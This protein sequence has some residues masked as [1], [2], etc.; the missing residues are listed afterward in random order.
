MS[1]KK[2]GFVAGIA[3]ALS[4]VVS[5]AFAACSLTTMSECDN[6]GLMTLIASLLGGSSTTTTTTTTTGASISGIPAGFTFTTN[7]KQGT[8][9]NDVKYLQVLLNSN[10]ATSIGNAGKETTYFGAMTK[11]AVVKFQNFYKSETLTPYGLTAGT[12]FFGSSSRAKANALIAGGTTGTVTTYPA[13]CTSSTGFSSTTGQSCAGGTTTTPVVVGS[14]FT[15]ILASNNP[16]ANALVAGQA[17]SDIAHYT[18]SNGT[19]AAVNVTSVELTRIGISADS[20]LANVYLFNGATRVTDAGSVSSGKVT[21]NNAAGLFT[22]PANSAVTISV[23]SDI[24]TG[25]A[26]QTVGVS[27]SAVTSTGTLANTVLPI[28]GNLFTI[29]TAP[30]LATVRIAAPTPTLVNGTPTPTDPV[31]GVRVWESTFTLSNNVTFTRLALKQINS[32]NSTDIGNFQLL[33]N[34]ELVS[35]V[36]SLDSNNYVTFSFNKTL[37]GSPDV[38]VLAD[39]NGGSSRIVQMSLRSAADI[40]IKD[41]QYGVNLAPLS[42]SLPASANGM[43][44]NSGQFTVA[45]DN[46]V[47]P[48][49][50]SNQATNVRIGKFTFKATGEAVKVDTITAGFSTTGAATALK[51]GKIFI[52][53]IQA[54]STANLALATA[55]TGGTSYTVNYTFQ[56]GVVTTV[57]IYADIIAATGTLAPTNLITGYIVRG[58][59]NGTP[60]ISLSTINVPSSGMNAASVSVGTGSATIAVTSN[61]GAQT[62]VAPQTAFKIG[63]WNITAGTSENINVND[64]V[65]GVNGTHGFDS[66]DL[67]NMYVTYQVGSGSAVTTSI[68]PT[69][70]TSNDFPVSFTLPMTQTVQVS[71]YSDI[72][73]GATSSNPGDYISLTVGA[74]GATSGT[75]V[76]FT[77]YDTLNVGGSN[78]AKLGQVITIGGSSLTVAQDPSTPVA[79]LTA[80]NQTISTAAFKFTATNDS[81]TLPQL[82]F[83]IFNSSAVSSVNLMDGTTIIQTKPAAATV[84]FNGFATTPSVAA[85]TTKILS[86]QLV[87][88]D[89]SASSGVSGSNVKT[90]F[91]AATS[92]VRPSATGAAQAANTS[93]YNISNIDGNAIYVYKSVPTITNLTLPTSSLSTG[94]NII[95]KFSVNTNGTGTVAWKKI[96]FNVNK[97]TGPV[98]ANAAAVS[99][100]NADSNTQVQGVGTPSSNLTAGGAASGTI[101]FYPNV[102]EQVSGTRNYTLKINNSGAAATTDTINTSIANGTGITAPEAKT[103]IYED[104]AGLG[105]VDATDI[106]QQT[107]ANLTA[108]TTGAGSVTSTTFTKV[109]N[110]TTITGTLTF[111]NATSATNAGGT[112]GWSVVTSGA[113]GF[114]ATNTATGEVITVVGTALT[115]SVYTTVVTVGTS[116]APGTA[117]EAGNSDIGLI[118]TSSVSKNATFVWSDTSAQG[119]SLTTADWTNDYLV[120]S[121]PTDSQNLRGQ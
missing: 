34:G 108:V 40:D 109:P 80:A 15:V 57:E 60:Q 35:T 49:T 13:G 114:V 83:D 22:V 58:S 110:G 79:T 25:T 77:G 33:I 118:I 17:T 81:F 23:K 103:F 87:L 37:S 5:P 26:G 92:L 27:L 2:L 76:V 96:T 21:F 8:T 105:T 39:I 63:S 9:S 84:T 93:P 68:K 112:T 91:N 78:T 52:N 32:I 62:T 30:D 29:A 66:A 67:A 19:S 70:G 10:A 111:N 73:S 104:V 61:Y 95:A 74:N 100:W 71:L 6:N 72:L 86:V 54:G 119:H 94:T 82:T 24:A 97:S 56:P 99:L 64:F 85:N 117:V 28:A 31:A 98:I 90:T 3:F 42:G 18:F 41:A 4:V 11:A 53:G 106:R 36:A 107:T 116:F 59:G 113:T 101:T 38:K 48:I 43:S 75:A 45:T 16:A 120:K 46:T 88:G 50:V 89:V 44:V 47:L 115:T 55:T 102:E 12:G 51:N 65:F 20:T 69:A 121:I 1:T 14:G 7:L